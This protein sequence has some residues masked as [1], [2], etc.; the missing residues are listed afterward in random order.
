M[1]GK[2]NQEVLTLKLEIPIC[3]NSEIRKPEF[4]AQMR[5]LNNKSAMTLGRVH[6]GCRVLNQPSQDGLP[7]RLQWAMT[8][9]IRYL[10]QLMDEA[11]EEQIVKL[12]E[13]KD[14]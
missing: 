13:T 5:L 14:G 1:S 10:L 8:D 4:I 7:G 3:V 11:Y 2:T 12:K 9:S 6:T